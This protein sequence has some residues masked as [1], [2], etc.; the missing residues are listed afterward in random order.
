[1]LRVERENLGPGRA[2]D[3]RV[4]PLSLNTQHPTLSLRRPILVGHRGAAG[5]APENTLAS[6][7]RALELGVDA[8]ELDV[9]RTADGHLVVIHDATVDRTTEGV[10]VVA[11]MSLEDIRRLDAGSWYG[12]EYAGQRVPVPREALDLICP[13]ALCCVE[14][15]EPGLAARVTAEIRE[16]GAAERV[17]LLSFDASYGSALK[18]VA[19]NL[20][21]VLLGAPSAEEVA[22]DPAAWVERAAASKAVALSLQY[23]G[24]SPVL[25]QEARKARVEVW[26]WTVNEADDMRRLAANGVDGIASDRPDVLVRCFG[27]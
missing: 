11:D 20:P 4:M 23:R 17:L 3:E 12:I 9:R 16:A 18:S 15:K 19:P 13:S 14:L 24:I 22:S 5:L 21:F 8:V 1:M 25:V 6:F 7:S 2:D 10:G 27:I 26:A